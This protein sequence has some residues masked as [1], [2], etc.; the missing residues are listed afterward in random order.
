MGLYALFTG[1]ALPL[2][3]KHV[4]YLI[5]NTLRIQYKHRPFL[6]LVFKDISTYSEKHTEPLNRLTFCGQNAVSSNYMTSGVHSNQCPL[7][8]YKLLSLL[9]FFTSLSALK[10]LRIAR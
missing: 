3:F 4:S 2:V 8:D 10:Y 1:I 7:K 5:E 9:K 6:A